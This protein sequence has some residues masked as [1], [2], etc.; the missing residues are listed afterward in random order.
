MNLFNYTIILPS[1][2]ISSLMTTML[3]N[4]MSIWFI[5]EISNFMFISYLIS[6]TKQKKMIFLYFLIQ[7]L[8]SI[9]ILYSMIINPIQL[10]FINQ[11]MMMMSLF[12]KS[13]IPPL[14]LWMPLVSKFISWTSIFLML[15]IQ[16][17]PPLMFF[18]LINIKEE[19]FMFMMIMTMLVPPMSMLNLNSMKMLI[20]YSSI[21]QT[22]WII[23]L[24]FLKHLLWFIYFMIYSMILLLISLLFEFTSLSKKFFMY[25]FKKL[26]TS[27]TVIIMNLA[28]MPPFSF[29]MMKWFSTFMVILN[30]NLKFL[31]ILLL[32]NSLLMTFIYIKMIMWS[33]FL[34]KFNSKMIMHKSYLNFNK[35]LF[36]IVSSILPIIMML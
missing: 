28:S 19:M 10:I 15:S 34:N 35:S 26:N 22:G 8:A 36:M 29:F 5:M 1:I 6:S 25:T 24:I 20:V 13:G 18:F 33:L 9:M 12:M 7:I 3:S 11:S 32:F 16:K 17:I 31:I 2:I 23:M 14:H 30:S 27:F 21:N 4:L